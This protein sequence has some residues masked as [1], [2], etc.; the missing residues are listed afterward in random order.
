MLTRPLNA[1]QIVAT[2][3]K[4]LAE[5]ERLRTE[6]TAAII[7]ST[8]DKRLIVSGPGTGK[9][10][11]FEAALGACGGKGLALTFLRNLVADLTVVLGDRA[12]VFTFHGYCKY[13]MHHHNI[14]GLRDGDYYPPLLDLLID[15]IQVLE[16]KV[17]DGDDVT[18]HLHTLDDSDGLIGEVLACA[19]YYNAVSHTDLVYRVLRHFEAASDTIPTFP[20]IVVDEYQDFS[21]LETTFI[22]L[23]ATKSKVLIAGDDDQ[24]LYG[25]LRNAEADFIRALAGEG[26]FETFELPYCVRCTSVIVAAVNDLLAAATARGNLARRLT[27]SFECYLPDKGA[28]SEANPK[29]IHVQCS[30]ANTPYAGQYIAQQ[31]ARIPRVDIATSREKGYPTALVI[32]PNPFLN[33][34]YQVV[35]QRFPKARM[36]TSSEVPID[37]LDGYRRI[38]RND[39]SRLGW[40]IIIA[41]YPF[42]GWKTVLKQVL[43]AGAE[44]ADQLPEVYRDEHSEIA[45]L[46]G[47]MLES[48]T[49]STEDQDRLTTA[50]GRSSDEIKAALAIDEPEDT[51]IEDETGGV[52]GE[53]EPDILFTS[54]VGSKGLSA[55]H[56]FVVGLNDGHLPRRRTAPTDEEVCNLLVALSRT[57]KRCHVV[58]CKFFGKGFLT[59]SL[60][61]DWIRPHLEAI[62]VDKNYDF[63]E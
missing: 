3:P 10:F 5:M 36:K 28:D 7:G 49:L 63:S 13:L 55:E 25:K 42:D 30:T 23:L 27:K 58:S 6:A 54:L 51:E 14:A 46:L 45:R 29:I 17:I 35:Q 60:F 44:L 11:T 56:V 47:V 62:E 1:E 2:D 50:T 39:K 19:D 20:L 52:P 41:A 24:A 12:D 48:G 21:L 18:A 32:G 38:A 57:R 40:R 53:Y 8:A 59:E 9:T 37:A 34:A 4:R 61:L 16:G 22:Q 15:D 33:R 31:I 26:L 43:E